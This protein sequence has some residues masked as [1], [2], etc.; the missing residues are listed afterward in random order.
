MGSFTD[1]RFYCKTLPT[2]EMAHPMHF[3]FEIK[4]QLNCL[5]VPFLKSMQTEF[6]RLCFVTFKDKEY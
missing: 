3:L 6:M 2:L 5:T 1:N 4:M